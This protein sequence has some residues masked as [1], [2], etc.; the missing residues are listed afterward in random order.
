MEL[1][2]FATA[3]SVDDGKSTLIGRLALRLQAGLRGPDG[4]GRAL[5][6]RPRRRVRQPG[7][8]HRRPPC[9]A[10]AGHHDRRRIPLL[11]HSEAQVHHRR[12]ARPHPAHAQHGDGLLDCRSRDPARRRPH[13]ADRADPPPRHGGVSPRDPAPR[14]LHQQ[15]GPRRLRQE[16]LRGHSTRVRRL[17]H[18]PRGSRPHLHPDVGPPG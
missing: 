8:A 7:V 12:H 5:Q 9:R 14:S 16:A 18:P 2:R 17:R 1:L 3:G 15:D 13:R 6:P 11:R 10:G 4:G